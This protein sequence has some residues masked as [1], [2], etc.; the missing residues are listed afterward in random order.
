M[1][2]L[3]FELAGRVQIGALLDAGVLNLSQALPGAPAA[4]LDFLAAGAPALAAARRACE[5]PRELLALDQ[6]RLLAPVPRPG[7][8]LGVGGN[9]ESHLQEAAHLGFKRPTAPI[10][11]NKQTTSAAGPFDPILLPRDSAELDYEGELGLVIG[12]RCR[13]L[14]VE[15]A[16]EAVAGYVVC[17]DVSVR[18]WQMRS[19]TA[20]IGKSFDS[21]GPFGPWLVTPDE[22]G[23]PQALRMRTWVNGEL[24]QDGSTAEMLFGCAQLLADLSRFCTLEPGDVIACGSPA[25]CGGLRNPPAYLRPGDRVRVE[26][27]RVGAI[28][29]HVIDEP[30]GSC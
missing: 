2:L 19:P 1:K 4:M 20:T 18:D 10:W 11:F 27:E 16:L 22:V 6:L 7:K 15:Q 9:F 21:H 23:D 28:E 17:N 5:Q 3:S 13:R 8:F 26:I 25:G 24:R 14:S 29:N 30:L 12:R